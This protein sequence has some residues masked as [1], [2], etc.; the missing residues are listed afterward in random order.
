MK[1]EERTVSKERGDQ[2]ETE[3]EPRRPT[4]K[5]KWRG[6]L[7]TSRILYYEGKWMRKGRFKNA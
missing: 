1:A 7:Y 4:E 6:W 3:E 5:S 2:K